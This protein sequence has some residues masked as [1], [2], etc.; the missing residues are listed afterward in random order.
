MGLGQNFLT[1]VGLGQFFVARVGSSL[2]SHLWFWFE[3]EKFT[4]KICQIF[5]F[6]SLRVG[7][8]STWVKGRSVPYLLRVKSKLG[9]GQGPSLANTLVVD[10][11]ILTFLH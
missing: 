11:Y 5:Q 9:L 3:F 6:F 4:L 1:Q 7:S 10:F 2:V 8:K